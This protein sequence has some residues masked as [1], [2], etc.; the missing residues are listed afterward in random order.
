MSPVAPFFA[1][2]LYTDLNKVTHRETFESVHLAYFPEYNEALVNK[3]L[4]ER[5]QMAQDISSLVLSLRKKVGINVRQPLGRILLPI[6]DKNFEYQVEQVKELILSETNVK[7]IEYITDASGFIKKKIRPNFKAL[8]AK[9]GKDMKAVAEAIGILIADE[10]AMLE[11]A[12]EIQLSTGHTLLITD[13]EIIAEDVPGWQVANLGKLTVALDVTLTNELKQ[14]GL[15]REVINRIQN[16]RKNMGLEVTD[17]ITV[18]IKCPAYIWEAVNN[19]LSYICAEILAD[20]ILLDNEL[21]EGEK[22]EIDG[23]EIMIVISKT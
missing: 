23:H 19:N 5:M 13:V 1:D 21:T 2:K 17:R 3:A 20:S 8:G 11:A 16:Q 6:L 7:T 4:E 9:V 15:A 22:T 12:R 18:R 10:I 14:E